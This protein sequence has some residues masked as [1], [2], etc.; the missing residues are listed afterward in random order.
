MGLCWDQ[1]NPEAA[2]Q[3]IASGFIGVV[4]QSHHTVETKPNLQ[5]YSSV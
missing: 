2:D 5:L 4:P 3:R 1:A